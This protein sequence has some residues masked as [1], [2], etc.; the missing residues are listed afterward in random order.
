E[1]H[2]ASL[3]AAEWNRCRAPRVGEAAYFS[4]RAPRRE[5]PNAQPE[6]RMRSALS[7]LEVLRPA[8]LY[9]ALAVMADGARRV[10]PIAGG[11]D[12]FVY[13]N[14]GTFDAT[15][16]MDLLRLRELRGIRVARGSITLGALTT[17]H[18]IRSDRAIQRRLP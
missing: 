6:A 17:F 4:L 13:L 11:T 1:A 3:R 15:R 14:A 2:L 7:T 5:A 10:T 18:E 8:N 16:Y 9:E 12:L